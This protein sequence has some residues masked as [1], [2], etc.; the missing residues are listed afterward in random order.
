MIQKS[1]DGIRPYIYDIGLQLIQEFVPC[2]GVFFQRLLPDIISESLLRSGKVVLDP[3]VK[4]NPISKKGPGLRSQGCF[5]PKHPVR[6]GVIGRI[7]LPLDV[8]IDFDRVAVRQPVIR[9]ICFLRI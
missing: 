6:E 8:G 3:V 5:L 1:T 2:R 9:P 4:G 7:V